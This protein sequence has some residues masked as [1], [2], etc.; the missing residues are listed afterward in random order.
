MEITR[1]E[2]TFPSASGLCDIQT[3]AFI[4]ENVKATVQ[5]AHGMAEHAL[6]YTWFAEQLCNAGYAVYINDHLGHGKSVKNDDMLGFF[7]GTKGYMHIVNDC[8]NLNRL[9]K[10]EYPNVPHFFFGHSMG[11]FIARCYSK[12]YGDSIDAAVYC[13][14]SGANPGAAAGIVMSNTISKFKGEMYR[15]S[16]INSIAFGSY[17]K[18]TEGRTPFDWLTKD[19]AVVDAYIE[20]KY[21]GFCFTTAGFRDLFSVLS[22]VSKKDWYTSVPTKLPILLIAGEDDPVGA[23]G[24]GVTEVYNGLKD[25]GHNVEMK[26]YP[27]DRH[28]IHNELDK[29]QVVADLIAFFDANI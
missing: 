1:K 26:L 2:F 4:P 20:D 16:L 13:G 22:E 17:N 27:N 21:C 6:R 9:I 3:Y 28:E 12:Y 11:S 15:S 25:S 24:K 10:E 18:K 29:D 5:I 14:T 7:G 23:Y 19:S 8:K